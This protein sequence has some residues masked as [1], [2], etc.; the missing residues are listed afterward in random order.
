MSRGQDR[1]TFFAVVAAVIIAVVGYMRLGELFPGGVAGRDDV[2][3][4]GEGGEM[5]EETEKEGEKDLEEADPMALEGARSG[6]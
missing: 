2:A 6:G 3:E 4:Q 5:V 1:L